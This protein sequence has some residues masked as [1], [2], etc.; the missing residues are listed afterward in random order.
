[1]LTRLGL[2]MPD[3]TDPARRFGV[4]G[5]SRPTPL[6][7]PLLPPL[8]Q[9]I[10]SLILPESESDVDVFEQQALL[11][12]TN[13]EDDEAAAETP[14]NVVTARWISSFLEPLTPIAQQIV[15][16]AAMSSLARRNPSWVTTYA[17]GVIW[18]LVATLPEDDPWRRLSARVDLD[19]LSIGRSI[20]NGQSLLWQ[21]D[22]AVGPTRTGAFRPDGASF[23]T[24]RDGTDLS[25]TPVNDDPTLDVGLVPL[26][27]SLSPL[28]AAIFGLAN[29]PVEEFASDLTQ[30]NHALWRA[31]MAHEGDHARAGVFL[32]WS[33]KASMR[34]AMWRRQ[35]YVGR[36]DQYSQ[37]VAYS[38]LIKARNVLN[39]E[40]FAAQTTDVET[41]VIEHGL[42]SVLAD[43]H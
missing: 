4:A 29:K 9:E 33:V 43:G 14:A 3:S 26:V 13:D 30:I 10:Q 8:A 37:H 31:A 19:V 7:L 40:P 6:R 34:W 24:W 11:G 22:G 32:L 5:G 17:T 36:D 28:S 27:P 23:G 1:M 16:T 18:E 42:Y 2:A 25:G 15:N 39:G 41:G 20:E 38:W 21:P 12:W 35:C